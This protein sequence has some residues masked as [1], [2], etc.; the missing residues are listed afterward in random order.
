VSAS[1]RLA[2]LGPYGTFTEQALRTQ[3]D[4]ADTELV[5]MRTFGQILDSVADGSVERGFVAIENALEGTV[6]A[7][8][9]SLAFDNHLLIQREVLLDIEMNLMA[10]PGTEMADIKVVAS[11]P[12]ANGQCREFLAKEMGHAEIRVATSTAEAAQ[13]V[14][15]NPGQA[16]LCNTL[17]GEL[18]GLA[19]VSTNVADRVNNQTRF[20]LV[21]RTGVPAASGDDKTTLA[22]FQRQNKPG[23]LLAILQQ[24]ASRNINLTKLTS[25][26][27][28]TVMGQYCF[29]IDAEGHIGD[30]VL[31]DALVN[32]KADLA[33]VRFL[34]S[35]PRAARRPSTS[36]GAADIE[37][38]HAEEWLADIHS[39]IGLGG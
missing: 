8:L 22:I 7:T 17:A 14:A 39:Q 24:F 10:L 28:K 9:D 2:F 23:S 31:A 11:H 3:P 18:Y 34:G 35:Y 21:G 1:N 33:E 20:V 19:T 16:A 26:P 6:N 5:P 37:P 38:G 15:E 4:L 36:T 25:R 29:L 27:A 13:M 32:I 30:R 12:V